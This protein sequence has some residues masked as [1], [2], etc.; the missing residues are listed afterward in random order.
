MLKILKMCINPQ[1]KVV[2]DKCI[3]NSVWVT[4]AKYF[5]TSGI[6]LESKYHF[7][8]F[9]SLPKNKWILWSATERVGNQRELTKKKVNKNSTIIVVSARIEKHK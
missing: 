9:L 6:Y 2:P 8:F 4:F 3:I 7:F 1:L 5:S